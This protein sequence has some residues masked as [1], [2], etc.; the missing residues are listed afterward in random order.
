MGGTVHPAWVRD[1]VRSGPCPCCLLDSQ[2]RPPDGRESMGKTAVVKGT[3]CTLGEQR[4]T[5]PGGKS[6]QA[7]PGSTPPGPQ[8]WCCCWSLAPGPLASRPPG[9]L[10]EQVLVLA[11]SPPQQRSRAGGLLGDLGQLWPWEQIDQGALKQLS[12]C[13]PAKPGTRREPGID[14][15]RWHGEGNS[16]KPAESWLRAGV[17]ICACPM[18]GREEGGT[19]TGVLTIP[20]PRG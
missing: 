17:L 5:D 9:L 10:V 3:P 11:S 12:V 19:A 7:F 20:W 2:E 15:G 18:L 16:G 14:P 1:G 13:H 4:K 8:R 6:L